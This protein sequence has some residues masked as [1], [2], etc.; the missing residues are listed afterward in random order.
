VTDSQDAAVIA[1][2]VEAIAGAVVAGVV[3][4]AGAVVASAV[5]VAGAATS[6]LLPQAATNKATRTSGQKFFTSHCLTTFDSR[7]IET[8]FGPAVIRRGAG[9]RC[10]LLPFVQL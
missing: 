3:A 10:G 7:K 2:A 5:A 9:L 1:V 4:I 8:P 6:E